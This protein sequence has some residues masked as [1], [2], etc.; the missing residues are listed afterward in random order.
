MAVE[1]PRVAQG[2]MTMSDRLLK[3]LGMLDSTNSTTSTG[4]NDDN[5]SSAFYFGES[6]VLQWRYVSLSANTCA[7][8]MMGM[9]TP[10]ATSSSSSSS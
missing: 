4:S 6:F 7:A 3:V 9:D 10:V 2:A 8:A 1:K 5:F